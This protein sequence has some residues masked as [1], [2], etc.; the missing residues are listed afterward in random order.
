MIDEYLPMDSIRYGVVE[1][2][3]A[4]NNY[5]LEGNLDQRLRN[6][7]DYIR[8]FWVGVVGVETLSTFEAPRRT[9]NHLESFHSRLLEA[10]GI[11]LDVWNFIRKL[12][13]VEHT[14]FCNLQRI[15]RAEDPQEIRR[16]RHSDNVTEDIRSAMSRLT[17][18]RITVIQFLMKVGHCADNIIVLN[19]RQERTT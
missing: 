11:N 3:D 14:A 7:V 19:R 6:L 8:R 16:R 1:G 10:F 17:A 9:N 18:G 2:L 13:T 12:R 5:I 4:V 15:N